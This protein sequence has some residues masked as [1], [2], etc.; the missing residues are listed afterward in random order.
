MSRIFF[1][2]GDVKVAFSGVCKMVDYAF[3]TVVWQLSEVQRMY[4]LCW[5]EIG[6]QEM[7]A[8]K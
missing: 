2:Q 3:A 8:M 4:R 6:Q 7:E 1:W 5:R